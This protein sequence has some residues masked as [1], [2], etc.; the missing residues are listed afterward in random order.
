MRTKLN[1]AVF[2][3]VILLLAAGAFFMTHAEM[4]PWSYLVSG[5]SVLLFLIPTAIAAVRWLGRFHAAI[6]F[7]LLGVYALTI[8]TTAVV[9]GFPYGHFYYSD[10]LGFKI[11]G[12]VPWAVFFAWTP[13]LLAAY[14]CARTI[15]RSAALRVAAI[16]V[17]VTAFD[18]VLDPGAVKAGFW[19]FEESGEYYGVPVSNF[20]GWILSGAVGALILELVFKIIRP[21]LPVPVQLMQSGFLT[22]FYWTF[23]A[24]FA[25]MFLPAAIG[26]GLTVILGLI[27]FRYHYS[28]DEM[29]VLVDEE[30]R[31][32]GTAPKLPVH[33][34]E[35]PLHRAFSVFLFNR[36][37]ELLLQR[38]AEHKKTW[39]GVWSNSCCGHV[40][41]HEPVRRAAKRR[42]KYELGIKGVELT[43]VLPDYRY[44]AEK[45]GIVE[46]EICPVLVG[47]A[48]ADPVINPD[49]V[50]SC[51][52]ISWEE[53]LKEAA[54]PD[55]RFS[56]WAVEEARLLSE[57]EEFNDWYEKVTS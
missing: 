15:F 5:A 46:N 31:P 32:I 52:W 55:T 45:D 35:T 23:V 8:E 2:I 6:V 22:I 57:S 1:I 40:M 4:P 3:P 53:F 18:M 43:N 19:T 50:D 9:T 47:F 37:G 51:D 10:E 20:V 39:G 21:L 30:N 16:A 11:Y 33:T 13:L 38:R 34:Q 41:L 48:D 17:L 25:G 14:V 27:Y 44:R 54:D 29:V 49:E 12:I 56:P 42:L 24:V 7:L 36:K 26:A 28:F